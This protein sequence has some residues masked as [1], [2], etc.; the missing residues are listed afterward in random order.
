MAQAFMPAPLVLDINPERPIL[1]RR[2]F[3]TSVHELTTKKRILDKEGLI[4]L[5]EDAGKPVRI[6]A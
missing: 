3:S 1:V 2:L 5:A 6:M 4:K